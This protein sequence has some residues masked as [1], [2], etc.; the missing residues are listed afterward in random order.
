[1]ILAALFDYRSRRIPNWLTLAGAV[2]GVILQ[3]SLHRADGLIT[4][5]EGLGLALLI[6]LPLYLLR[7]VGGG[8]VK[9]MAAVGAMAGP[10][11][12]LAIMLVTALAGGISAIF[13]V[14]WK[15]RIGQTFRNIRAAIASL[16]RG[17]A[18]FKNNPELDVRSEEALRMPHAIV[19][20]CGTVL[21]L[22]AVR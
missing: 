2:T 9:L 17:R 1:M 8:D 21:Y 19:I 20:A 13:L 15:H 3:S 16:G 6:Y 4:S 14:A 12:W 5:L 18:P 10:R 22:I 7:G 11:N